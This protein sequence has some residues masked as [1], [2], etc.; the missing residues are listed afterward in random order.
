MEKYLSTCSP[1]DLLK[2]KIVK[3]QLRNLTRYLKKNYEKQLIQN[4]LKSRPKACWQCVNSKVKTHPNIIELLH[5]DGTTA[6]SDTEMATILN[7][8]FSSVYLRRYHLLPCSGSNWQS[9]DSYLI[10]SGLSQR[11]V[12]YSK[13]YELTQ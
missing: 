4:I 11:E 2:F 7:D 5:S 8:Y 12:V 9:S 6:N 3:N 13:N 1:T 10:Q